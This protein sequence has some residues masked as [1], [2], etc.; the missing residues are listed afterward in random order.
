M[1][2]LS[3]LPGSA[4][5]RIRF[6]VWL[7]CIVPLG[8]LLAFIGQQFFSF[9][10]L[11]WS[12]GF[13]H[14]LTGWDHLLTM[15]GVGIW[16]AQLRGHAIWL[17]PLA[18]VGVMSLGGLA[19]AAG[20]DIPSVEGIILLSCAVFSVLITR[21][22]RFSGKVN[23]LIVAFFAFF[24]GFAHGHE[25][26]TS[27]SLVSYTLGFMLATLLLHG[28]GILVAKLVILT[29]AFMFS[30]IFSSTALAK[31][32]MSFNKTSE[33][34]SLS[35]L[36]QNAG[37]GLVPSQVG[38]LA[39]ESAFANSSLDPAVEHFDP[40][41][42]QVAVS[43]SHARIDGQYW[44]HKMR[45]PVVAAISQQGDSPSIRFH[46]V[47]DMLQTRQ[48]VDSQPLRWVFRRHFPQINHTPGK[49]LLSNGA[50]LTSPPLATV[51]DPLIPPVA[52]SFRHT[53]T[54]D[55]EAQ[56]LQS[57]SLLRRVGTGQHAYSLYRHYLTVKTSR[58]S[59]LLGPLA[60]LDLYQ[61]RIYA[62]HSFWA[63]QR[64]AL[65]SSVPV[66]LTIGFPSKPSN[67]HFS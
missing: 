35:P 32:S 40:D 38:F 44:R 7:S 34:F 41:G 14:P 50:G 65:E 45:A 37:V 67:D 30:A 23:V 9:D 43:E 17:L 62:F 48:E 19:G 15:L 26:S 46:A 36:S 29:L 59:L 1:P 24:H 10:S 52:L 39:A 21:R 11:D 58:I 51:H 42:A 60:P 64:C 31:A 16:A 28:A 63:C 5:V 22:M 6:R 55:F 18:F 20:F 3:F 53:P 49:R 2:F 66:F 61:P 12:D 56:S 47:L 13:N 8:L 4:L 25:I 54:P 57:K 33:T 27:A